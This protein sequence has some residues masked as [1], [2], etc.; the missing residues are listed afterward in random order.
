VDF[1]ILSLGTVFPLSFAI[2]QCYS[3]RE[4]AAGLITA[5]RVSCIALY[6]MY[7]NFMDPGKVRRRRR[8]RAQPP[9]LPAP[10]AA[11]MY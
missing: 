7:F 10:H 4:A 3:R 5:L 11:A 6:Q 2:S 1:G 9:P 8:G